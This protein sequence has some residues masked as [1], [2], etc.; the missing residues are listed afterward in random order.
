LRLL[1]EPLTTFE[2]YS[3][4]QT[5]QLIADA[6]DRFV[7]VRRVFSKLPEAN[8]IS[9]KRVLRLLRLYSDHSEKN[10]MSVKNLAVCF[11]P[12]KKRQRKSFC[13]FQKDS[14]KKGVVSRS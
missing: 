5:A 13:R 6:Q 14:K 10:K 1:P 8:L 3:V 12:V 9:L 4:I 11:A 2:A 7:F